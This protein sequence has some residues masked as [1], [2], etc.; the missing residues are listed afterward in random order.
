MSR[1]FLFLGTRAEDD[2]A[3]EEFEAVRRFCQLP[4]S[5]LDWLRVE[6]APLPAID[7][8]RY[9]G[10]ITGGSP[11]NS[12]DPIEI[13]SAVQRRVEADLGRLLDEIVARDLPFFGAC[14]GIGTLG[15]HQGATIDRTY[16]EPPGA[17]HI[18]LT[19]E[20]AADPI[21]AGLPLEFDAFV[22]HKEAVRTLPPNG[23]LLATSGPCPVQMF[24]IRTNL[25]ATQFHP[26]LDA[27]GLISRLAAYR[28]HG[29][30]EPNE[31]DRL[32]NEAQAANVEHAPTV[33][34]NFAE[35]YG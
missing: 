22:G 12:S 7:L 21:C 5:R 9:A 26:E 1:P 23:V 33:L 16:G 29:Y 11:F 13:K 10:I 14:Y 6:Q 31:L 8:D 28:N 17:S 4:E 32:V 20:G 34:R 24:R 27:A 18:T 35:R 19:E 15:A 25:Y 3:T 2:I 30:F